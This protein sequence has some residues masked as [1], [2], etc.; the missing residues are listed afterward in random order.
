[1]DFFKV[2]ENRRAIRGFD[3]RPVEE[4]KLRA[5][6][7]AANAAP[8][9]GNQQ[10]YDIY[11]VRDVRRRSALSRAAYAQGFVLTAPVSLVFCASPARSDPR[12]GSRGR[13]LYS[14]Q[15]ATIACAFAMLAAVAQGLATVWTGAF[16]PE[17]VRAVIGEPENS[18][19]VA[20]LPIGYAAAEPE[21][22]VR[23]PLEELVHEV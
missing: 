4:E 2:V 14:V 23:R 16:D 12:Y 13:D 3:G 10:A 8:S 9:A 6:L 20:I 19:P 15:D 5:I 11:V 22:R 21:P 18:T 17:E 7:E 1:M